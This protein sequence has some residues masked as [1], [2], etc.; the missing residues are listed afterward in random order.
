MANDSVVSYTALMS[1]HSEEKVKPPKE[2]EEVVD[3][4][5]KNLAA[6]EELFQTQEKSGRSTPF[7]EHL[8]DVVKTEQQRAQQKVS[9]PVFGQV[10]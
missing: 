2:K 7:T 10:I 8:H 4:Y 9:G 1:D 5:L 6:K 3:E